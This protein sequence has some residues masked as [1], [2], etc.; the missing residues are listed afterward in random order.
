MKIN[1]LKYLLLF[2]IVLCNIWIVSGNSQGEKAAQAV[3]RWDKD[4][5]LSATQKT[6]IEAL[7]LQFIQQLDSINTLPLDFF[8]RQLIKKDAHSKLQS[9]I[10]SLLTEQQKTS[11][12]KAIAER[13]KLVDK[14]KKK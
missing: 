8:E 2:L 12:D 10:L 5:S 11:L 9:D 7:T 1:K 14:K 3:Q 13:K 4:V 6:Q